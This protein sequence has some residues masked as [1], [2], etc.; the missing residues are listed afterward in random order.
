MTIPHWTPPR[1]EQV[2]GILITTLGVL[3]FTPDTLFIRLISVDSLSLAFWRSGISGLVIL[4]ALLV[5]GQ[6][7]QVISM[8][9]TGWRGMIY[10]LI[11]AFATLLFIYAIRTTTVANTMI[12]LSTSPMFA[13]IASRILLKEKINRRLAW[14]IGLSMFGIGIVAAGSSGDQNSSFNGDLAAL[15]VAVCLGIKHT[16]AR[17][18]RQ[19]SMVPAV[20]MGQLLLAI[21]LVFLVD[22]TPITGR[23]LIYLLVLAIVFMPMATSLMA[24]GPRYITAPEVGLILLLEVII[25]PLLIWAVLGEVPSGNAIIGGALLIAVIATYNF[26]QLRSRL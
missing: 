9:G 14:A 11:M 18:M 17:S 23:D 24:L 2:T 12:I 25:A 1:N 4:I 6:S 22:I 3:A 8:L 20:A 26:L 16:I 13:A 7:R 21:T 19:I 5:A 15:V 10:I